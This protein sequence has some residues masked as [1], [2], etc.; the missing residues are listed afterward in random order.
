MSEQRERREIGIVTAPTKTLEFSFRTQYNIQLGQFVMAIDRNDARQIL[1]MVRDITRVDSTS[2]CECEV[3][4]EL[5]GNRLREPKRP[6]SPGSTVVIPPGEIIGNILL[7]S[8]K[9]PRLLIGRLMAHP[10]LVPVYY[11][12]ND[13]AR[14]ILLVAS[15]GAGKSYT[16]SVFIE[17]ILRNME[18]EDI[19]ILIIDVHNEY[20]GLALPNKFEDQVQE[21]AEFGLE[22]SGFEDRLLIFDWNYNPPRIGKNFDA[23]RFSFVFSAKDFKWFIYIEDIMRRRKKKEMSI[24]EMIDA[25]QISD[26]HPQTKNA[27]IRRLKALLTS[28][29][30]SDVDLDPEDF[31]KPGKATIFRLADTPGGDMMIRFVVADILR[32][33]FDKAKARKLKTKVIIVIE[34]AHFFAPARGQ[35]DPVR[36]IIERISREGRKYGVWLMLIT[37]S[38]R[39]LAPIL[40]TN[41]N[42]YIALRL[43]RRDAT[44]VAE[45][46][47]MKIR[48][49]RDLLTKL[50][51]GYGY[52]QAPSLLVPTLVKIRPRM[53]CEVKEPH[54]S[55]I[56]EKVKEIALKTKQM[57]D[58]IISKKYKKLEEKKKI[59]KKEEV[60]VPREPKRREIREIK[61]Q[62]SPRPIITPGMV[63]DI[64]ELEVIAHRLKASVANLGR[65]ALRVVQTLASLGGEAPIEMF[66]DVSE[67][68]LD[69]LM[70]LGVIAIRRDKVLLNRIY[71]E[72]QLGKKLSDEKWHT[73]LEIIKQVLSPGRS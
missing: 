17:E 14:H 41:A 40:L 72:I 55:E 9:G 66:P 59:P 8:Y 71:F 35:Q 22:P 6:V 70:W 67:E 7:G 62:V 53:S 27:I 10:E 48:K 50:D 23:H 30:L 64:G 49:L 69:A 58:E 36:E 33:I 52:L 32:K 29:V 15:T 54:I 44:R 5:H 68:T 12:F 51:P 11:P 25:I 73:L 46:L 24:E 42:S 4:G 34:E 28:G 37:Q 60:A 47:G 65:S 13:F 19:A 38:P 45:Y 20:G 43:S 3:L 57:I 39:D 1:A 18:N 31:L 16:A 21:L 2:I 26:L 63:P 61:E 56:E